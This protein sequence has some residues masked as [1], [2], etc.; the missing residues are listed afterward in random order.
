MMPQRAERPAQRATARRQRRRR[1]PRPLKIALGSLLAVVVVAALVASTVLDE[2]MRR[3]VERAMNEQ[4]VGY[5]VSIGELDFRL[6]DLGFDLEQLVLIQEAHRKPPVADLDRLKM[7]VDWWALLRLRVVADVD[8]VRPKVHVDRRHLAAEAEDDVPLD[9]RGW[10]DALEA[11]YPLKINRL[12]VSGGDVTYIDD[13]PKRPLRL[14]DVDFRADNIRNVASRGAYPSDVHLTATIFDSG[15]LRVDGDA[16]FLAKPHLAIKGDV[17]L[18]KV[19]LAYF[20]PIAERYNVVIE[21]GLMSAEGDFEYA[22][23]TKTAQLEEVVFDGLSVAYLNKPA[24]DEAVREVAQD[25][26]EAASEV[27]NDPGILLKMDELEVRNGF[28]RY[29]NQE[30]EPDYEITLSGVQLEVKN[31]SN[32]ANRPPAEMKLEAK[33]L[34]SGTLA[35]EGTFRPEANGPNF[36]LNLRIEHV[37][38]RAMN[39]LLKAHGNFDVTRG[40][41]SLFTEIHVKDRRIDG[42]VKPLFHDLDVYDREQDK[43]ENILQQAYEGVIGGV[44]GLLENQPRDEVATVADISGPLDDPNSS[45]LQVILR[46]IQ[47]AF[48][49]AILPGY[50]RESRGGG[51]R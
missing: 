45:T 3:Y 30:T 47:N 35:S 14:S 32:H 10:Q 37:D 25:T 46:L 49:K 42:Y 8:F 29:A 41:F 5:D 40:R 16:D 28:V 7:S 6:L 2:P 26:A 4:L 39:D 9:E 23:K 15:R 12:T 48:F 13:D 1:W 51:E 21:K 17:E 19:A 27:S 50:E 34:E 11:A 20:A 33:F 18:A 43:D 36:D 44:A 31:L 38:M 24:R 22:P